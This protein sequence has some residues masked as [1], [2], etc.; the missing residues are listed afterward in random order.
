MNVVPY[1]D[2]CCYLQGLV[3]IAPDYIKSRIKGGEFPAGLEDCYLTLQYINTH[4]EELGITDQIA[5][6]GDSGGGLMAFS[7]ALLAK[8]FIY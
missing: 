2:H 1:Y 8:V 3:V 7:V 4:K 5:V 6:T